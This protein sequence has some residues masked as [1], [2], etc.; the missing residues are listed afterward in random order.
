MGL[1]ARFEG[2]VQ[3]LPSRLEGAAHDVAALADLQQDIAI[4]VH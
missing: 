4:T 1:E 2:G 3:A